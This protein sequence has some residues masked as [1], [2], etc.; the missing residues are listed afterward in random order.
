LV[1]PAEYDKIEVFGSI[2]PNL[3]VV[4]SIAGL[5]GLIDNKGKEI[6]RPLYLKIGKFGEITK[7]LALVENY[8]NDFGM[9]DTNGKEVLPTTY[10]LN[11]IKAKYQ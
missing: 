5:Y 1:T 10:T 8:T 2:H 6:A 3:A 9:I 7:D 4:K 11:E